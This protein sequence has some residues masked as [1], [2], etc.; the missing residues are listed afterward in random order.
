MMKLLGVIFLVVSA[1]GAATNRSRIFGY[2][3]MFNASQLGLSRAEFDDLQQ[4]PGLDWVQKGV[5]VTNDTVSIT[6]NIARLPIYSY[7]FANAQVWTNPS[8]Q[9]IKFK[10]PD[11]VSVTNNQETQ[12]EI[13]Q[14]I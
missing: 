7:T 2:W 14:D 6:G 10:V 4:L 1:A 11:Q 5:D 3:R 8:D 13:V 12:T 9:T